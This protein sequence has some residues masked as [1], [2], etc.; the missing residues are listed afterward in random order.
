LRRDAAG[1]ATGWRGRFLADAVFLADFAPR[2]L[3]VLPAVAF[4][5]RL[6]ALLGRLVERRAA[7]LVRLDLVCF[8]RR[9]GMRL[10][11]SFSF[12]QP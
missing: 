1:R 5:V 8:L 4:R 9:P 2:M 12:R 11:I 3:R 6:A 7:E 10:A